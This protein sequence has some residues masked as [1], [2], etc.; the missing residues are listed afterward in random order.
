MKDQPFY[1]DTAYRQAFDKLKKRLVSAP[2]LAH[3]DPERPSM[4]ETDA[5]D[6][7]IAGVYS[8]KQTDRE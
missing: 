1:F 3:F 6:G 5:L 4:L 2:L 8:Q 7:V